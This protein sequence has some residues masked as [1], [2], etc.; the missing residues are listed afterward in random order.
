MRQRKECDGEESKRTASG[1][2]PV[3][4]FDMD[5]QLSNEDMQIS[6]KYNATSSFKRRYSDDN[7]P[8]SMSDDNIEENHH[9]AMKQH[10]QATQP[11]CYIAVL[12]D[13]AMKQ[14]LKERNSRL[15]DQER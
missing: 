11:Q 1:F 15:Q 10:I 8:C 5:D 7:R 9:I 6:N 13:P 12:N 4:M 2:Q 14:K 3:A